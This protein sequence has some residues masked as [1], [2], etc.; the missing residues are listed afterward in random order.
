[1]L[2]LVA[3]P[4]STTSVE[5]MWSYPQGVQPYYK[6]FVQTHNA[7]GAQLNMTVSTNHTLILKLE[8]G[9]RYNIYVKTIAAT[10]SEST[11]EQ[12]YSYTSKTL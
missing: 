11:V 3:I 6:Y 2:N 4:K 5:V 12:T 7:T 1:M 8:P 10:G 9:T